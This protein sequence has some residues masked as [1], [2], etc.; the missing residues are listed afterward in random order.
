MRPLGRLRTRVAFQTPRNR[1]W[2]ARRVPTL[3]DEDRRPLVH[4]HSRHVNASAGHDARVE[5][6]HPRTGE[7]AR[8]TSG[9]G[10]LNTRMDRLASERSCL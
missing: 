1:P 2:R 7:T 5:R 9:S 3:E 4:A 8:G 10:R 6:L